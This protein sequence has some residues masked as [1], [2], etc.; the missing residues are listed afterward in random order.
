MTFEEDYPEY[1]PEEERI[2]RRI[3]LVLMII[4]YL[5]AVAAAI[6]LGFVFVAAI[7]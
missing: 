2:D 4:T 6:S 7:K 1:G 5:L 3:D